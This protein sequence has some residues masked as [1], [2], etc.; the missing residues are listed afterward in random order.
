MD[1]LKIQANDMLE[2]PECAD[3]HLQLSLCFETGFGV[4][5]DVA[6]VLHHLRKASSHSVI[7]RSIRRRLEIA[8]DDQNLMKLDFTITVDH[9]IEHLMS[10]PLYFS[11]RVRLHQK[12]LV[13]NVNQPT[14]R[15]ELV[16]NIAN[17]GDHQLSYVSTD[18]P[19]VLARRKKLLDLASK[20]GD[21][22]LV[23]SLLSER[24][25]ASKELL[26]ALVKS[27]EYGHFS[28][29][30]LLAS[31]W[32]YATFESSRSSPL[33]WLIMFK[34]DEAEYLAKLLVRGPARVVD[35]VNA[36]SEGMINA[37]PPAGSEPTFFPEHCLQLVG[38]PLHWAV[39]TRNL[40]L[41]LLLLRFGADIHQRW[42]F[43]R[44]PENDYPSQLRPS[45]TPLE[46]AIELHLPEIIDALWTAT[47]P[48]KQADLVVSANLFH[49]IA[50]LPP[51]FL[52][53]MIHGA[54]HVA[55]LRKTIATLQGIGLDIADKDGHGQSVFMATLAE[56]DQELYVLDETLEASGRQEDIT[57]DGQ[58]AVTLVAATSSIRQQS[59]QR[60]QIASSIVID[61]NRTD[62]SGFNALH[63]LAVENNAKLCEV[64]LQR[65]DIDVNKRNS[66][67][68]TATHIAATFNAAAVLDLLLR[69]GAQIEMLDNDNQSA[70]NLSVSFRHKIT[71]MILMEAGA[72]TI[73]GN[74]GESSRA[75]IL[76]LA[77]SGPS[78]SDSMA[79]YLLDTYPQLSDATHLN[80]VDGLGWTP[81]HRAAYFGDYAGVA[82]LIRH[83]ADTQIRCPRRFP[84][85]KGRTA[86]EVVTHLLERLRAKKDLG[87]DHVR[88]TQEG[89]Q[90]I[91]TFR[92]RL[93]EVQVLLAQKLL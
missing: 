81:L 5:P 87:A 63:Y 26:S 30:E 48:T 79:S 4:E 46:L 65:M 34:E 31:R 91:D 42:S 14:W 45:C 69:N 2:T 37:M 55:A 17:E 39:G 21:T 44:A 41:V 3:S 54:E 60:M 93:E 10:S 70:L 43:T 82:A 61:I 8:C 38:S 53:R 7:A 85:A 62:S 36:V 57:A 13:A 77:V 51:P 33:H 40:P 35:N 27:C 18:T 92:S 66:K 22:S 83:G 47:S 75:S 25:W 6:K 90:A 64:L 89:A 20:V 74:E 71:T 68:A 52:R 84:I 88:I 58:N 72:S 16:G 19:G 9:Q 73:K 29:A 67:G 23:R 11:E 32:S 76:H 59:T 78:S 1:E 50:Q 80:F 56:P 12:I 15:A 28:A 86:L 24:N 49:R